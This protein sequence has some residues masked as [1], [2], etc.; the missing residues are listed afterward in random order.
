[1]RFVRF[2]ITR[3]VHY[4]GYK[5]EPGLYTDLTEADAANLS[6]PRPGLPNGYGRRLEDE[7]EQLPVESTQ[8]PVESTEPS[9][10]ST[11]ASVDSR[12][13][14]TVSAPQTSPEVTS[15]EASTPAVDPAAVTE[16]SSVT[17]GPDDQA[18]GSPDAN[19]GKP[20]DFACTVCGKSFADKADPVVS[21]EGHRRS[22][23][24]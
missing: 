23:K 6:A 14:D 21:L 3:S 13:A 17:T 11:E 2:E 22:K 7:P 15:D 10:D 24:H 16:P 1:M 4:G 9:G 12:Q 8:L 19:P 5:R 18:G 20:A